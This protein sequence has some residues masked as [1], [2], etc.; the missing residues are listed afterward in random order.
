MFFGALEP[1]IAFGRAARMSMNCGSYQ[2]RRA[3][4]ET[5]HCLEHG[6]D[7]IALHLVGPNLDRQDDEVEILKR[8]VQSVKEHPWSSHWH[9]PT[10]FLVDYNDG[11]PAKTRAPSLP[12]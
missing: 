12:L 6:L 5:R 3:A 8:F 7:E 9:E 1:A 2:V 11:E 10:G 4:C